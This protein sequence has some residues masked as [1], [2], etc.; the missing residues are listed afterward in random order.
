[1]DDERRG[2]P[3]YP[4]IADSELS[5]EATDTH[6]NTHVSE[7]SR[8]GCHLDITNPLPDGAPIDLSI[9]A[10][11]ELFHAKAKIVHTEEHMGAGV[12]FVEIDAT[13]QPILERWLADA[14][15]NSNH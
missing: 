1:M 11:G 5:E 8:T 3:R 6:L 12:Y 9:A 14:A 2:S 10:G 7:I 4:F 13:N 15:K